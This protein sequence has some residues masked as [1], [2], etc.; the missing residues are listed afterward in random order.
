MLIVFTSASNVKILSTIARLSGGT[1]EPIEKQTRLW[2]ENWKSKPTVGRKWEPFNREA[3][4]KFN[5][6]YL[7]KMLLC[8]KPNSVK[9]TRWVLKSLSNDQ[10]AFSGFTSLVDI[11]EDTLGYDKQIKLIPN[12]AFVEP[13]VLKQLEKSK[14]EELTSLRDELR[15]QDSTKLVTVNQILK[16][17]ENIAPVS[18]RRKKGKSPLFFYSVADQPFCL[19]NQMY[20][21]MVQ[22]T[23]LITKT[24]SEFAQEYNQKPRQFYTGSI[25]FMLDG[26]EIYIIDLGSPAVGFIADILFASEALGREPN[27]GLD[28]L[29]SYLGKDNQIYEGNSKELGFFKLEEQVLREGLT[30]RGKQVTKVE[31]NKYEINIDGQ[32]LP[33]DD[34][35][36]LTRNQPLRNKTLE[37]IK[38]QLSKL[39]IKIPKGIVT[40]PEKEELP[41]FVI[42]N[43]RDP[44]GITIKKKTFFGEYREGGGYFK[45]LVVPLWSRELKSGWAKSTLFEQF[46]PSLLNIDIKGDIE[47]KRCYEIRMYYC[48]GEEK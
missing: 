3:E 27:V 22:A 25:D 43:N 12:A 9:D 20:Q 30:K 11:T 29:A 39:N 2:Q 4:Q 37:M 42:N 41:S 35:D 16:E 24:F 10:T 33:T 19:P 15:E 46:V 28:I 14:Q 5:K 40:I 31:G 1:Y 47:G 6:E 7:T 48:A 26:D 44:Y 32:D 17:A 13:F 38:T 8:G 18:P 34:Y 36:Y 23:E 21:R 45:P